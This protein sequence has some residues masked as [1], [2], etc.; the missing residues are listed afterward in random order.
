MGTRRRRPLRK[1][2]AQGDC[3]SVR[4]CPAASDTCAGSGC[5]P[6]RRATASVATWPARPLGGRARR[7]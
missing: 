3:S 5:G 1:I 4:N 6:G 7:R 2:R